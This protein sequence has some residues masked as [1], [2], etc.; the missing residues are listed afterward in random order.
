[1]DSDDEWQNL[2]DATDGTAHQLIDVLS[3]IK[4][5]SFSHKLQSRLTSS[6]AQ[7]LDAVLE[8]ASRLRPVLQIVGNILTLKWFVFIHILKSSPTDIST[9][10]T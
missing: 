3:V 8:G 5:K 6:A 9:I 2:V 4:E 1:V 10:P 7:V